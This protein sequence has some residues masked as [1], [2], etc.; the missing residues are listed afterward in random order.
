MPPLYAAYHI[1]S[2][3]LITWL[4]VALALLAPYWIGPVK[5]KGKQRRSTVPDT[6]ELATDPSRIPPA[7]I[8]FVAENQRTLPALGFTNL[9]IIRQKTGVVILAESESGTVV[10]GIA[11]PKADGTVHSL[12][13]FTTLLRGGG[14]I[15][16]A[17]STLPSI[18]P[19]P[20][21]ESRARFPQVRDTSR[22]YA[23][24]TQRVAQAVAA[25]ARVER[26]TVAD[27]IAY[28]K[29]EEASGIAHAQN[30]GYWRR[31]GDHLV[32]TWKGAFLSAWRML[33]PWRSLALR[34]DERQLSS[35]TP[36]R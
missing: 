17:N 6:M 36:R 3:P 7:L 15:R 22:L 1:S 19:A 34:R 2:S 32:L 30:S 9:A 25:G 5:I 16:T 23:I 13:G 28:Q 4:I 26:L 35:L 21:G 33:P 14:K 12:I 31:S 29:R 24:H 8:P 10:T 27:P 20:R 11:I 18:L